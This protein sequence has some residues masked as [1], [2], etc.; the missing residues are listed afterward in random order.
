M[1]ALQATDV[2]VVAFRPV[3]GAQL[4]VLAPEVVMLVDEPLQNVEATGEMVIVGSAF[5]VTS[6]VSVKPETV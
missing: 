4:Y 1:V 3:E 2:P 5:T 6:I